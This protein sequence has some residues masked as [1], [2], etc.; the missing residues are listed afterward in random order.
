VEEFIKGREITVGIL[1]GKPLPVVEIQYPGVFFDYDA[2]YEH[3][4]GETL[5]LC[6]PENIS[7]DV[8]EKA[9]KSAVR[10]AEA[11]GCRDMTRIDFMVDAENNIFILEA[12]NIPGFTPSSL[13]PK[14]AA[15]AGIPFPQLCGT[16][17]RNAYLRN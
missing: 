1:C 8:Q 13:L 2:K 14:A 17:V 9:R 16:L 7:E 15:N 11:I 4:R 10:F 5:Y 12:N 3:K 6:P